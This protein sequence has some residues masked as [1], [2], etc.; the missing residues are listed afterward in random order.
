M[1]TP[2]EIRPTNVV[3]PIDR[4]AARVRAAQAE[5]WSP[6]GAPAGT[7]A[8]R[9]H[10][11]RQLTLGI[12]GLATLVQVIIWLIIGINTGHLDAPWWLWSLATGIVGGVVLT[13]VAYLHR[14][15]T[16]DRQ[17]AAARPRTFGSRS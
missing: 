16:A 9:L 17:F 1:N 4:V 10:V 8:D 5:I 3:S 15:A 11:A 12:A 7:V 13:G 2:N 14:T 6:S